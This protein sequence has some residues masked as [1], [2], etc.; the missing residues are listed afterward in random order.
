MKQFF[1]VFSLIC[2]SFFSFFSSV[3][4]H[5]FSIDAEIFALSNTGATWTDFE[6]YMLSIDDGEFE[7][8]IKLVENKISTALSLP[9][10]EHVANYAVANSDFT[11]FDIAEQIGD[12]PMLLE[13]GPEVIYSFLNTRLRP[14][15]WYT[16]SLEFF[17][18]F[19]KIG[20]TH[21]LWGID[22]IL[23][24]L[25]LIIC[26]PKTR[27]ILLL[28]TTFTIAHSLTIIIWWMD[29]FSISSFIV[30][31][32]ILISIC[33]MAVYAIF[34]QVGK[35]LN[36]YAETL[37]IFI[38]GLFHGLWF[39][40]FFRSILDVS[41]NIFFPI[42]AFNIWVELGQILVLIISLIFLHI[43]Y[44]LFPTQKDK[45]KNIFA[46]IFII[47]AVTMLPGLFG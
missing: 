28:I 3:K 35:S 23:F 26:L 13:I 44:K 46:A 2:V 4:A 12:D 40:W 20:F 16:I 32:M 36:V 14:D 27:R 22:H 10:K 41:E 5:N 39:A 29:I 24:L 38:L 1:L 31:W 8:G 15:G 45:L 30:E 21:I 18:Q 25:T 42:F 19:I 17:M 37:L 34:Q 7:E 9:W 11:Y 43:L 33:I 47:I 6:E